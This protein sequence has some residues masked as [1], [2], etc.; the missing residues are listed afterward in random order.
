MCR[1]WF[2]RAVFLFEPFG[3]IRSTPVRRITYADALRFGA[4]H[5]EVYEEHGFDL[6]SGRAEPPHQRA[7]P[8]AKLISQ[9]G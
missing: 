1:S 9:G 4:L 8:I 6:V 2:E 3:F 7:A 5:R